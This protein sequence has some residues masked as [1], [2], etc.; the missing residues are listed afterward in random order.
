MGSLKKGCCSLERGNDKKN[1][2][3]KDVKLESMGQKKTH[4]KGIDF[5]NI[6]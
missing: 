4:L 2:R 5:G 1:W 3:E 6:I